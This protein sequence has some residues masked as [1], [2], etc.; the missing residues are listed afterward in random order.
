MPKL[1]DQALRHFAFLVACL[2]L[3]LLFTALFSWLSVWANHQ[4]GWEGTVIGGIFTFAVSVPIVGVF[5]FGYFTASWLLNW[6]YASAQMAS[7]N[8]SVESV[9]QRWPEIF[10]PLPWRGR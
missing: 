3:S 2:A 5:I 9:K 6:R 8:E 1:R 7:E 10:G 4:R